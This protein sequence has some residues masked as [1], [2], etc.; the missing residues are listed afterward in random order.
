MKLLP[1]E[2]FTVLTVDPLSIVLQRLSAHVEET[3]LFRFSRNHAF[4]QGTLTESGFE[5]TR[6][7]HSRNSC[8]PLIRG[9]FEAQS[10]GT[11]VHVRMS[12]H[13]FVIGFIGV[14]GLCWYGTLIPLT[15]V[16]AMPAAIALL[17]LGMPTAVLVFFWMMFWVEVD[18][19]RQKLTQIIKGQ[20]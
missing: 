14:W 20:A 7:I 10:Q 15:L 16:G 19:D 8:I 1:R 13:P 9:Y 12:F 5:V 4:Y 18:R 11:A 3:Q 6:I 17:F 2:S